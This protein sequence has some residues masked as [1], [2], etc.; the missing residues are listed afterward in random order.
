MLVLIRVFVL[1]GIVRMERAAMPLDPSHSSHS[2]LDAFL[3]DRC[4]RSLSSDCHE[5]GGYYDSLPSIT[6]NILP[7][8]VRK[9][10][11]AMSCHVIAN[12]PILTL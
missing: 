3:S 1:A 10:E 6:V 12:N 8:L 5:R 7:E 4:Y 11:E 9:R 2:D